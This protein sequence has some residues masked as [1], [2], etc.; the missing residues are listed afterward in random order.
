MMTHSLVSVK[1]LD[2]NITYS[3]SKRKALLKCHFHD[4]SIA[5]I[6]HFI[7][8]CFCLIKHQVRFLFIL[9]SAKVQSYYMPI[10][11]KG[12]QTTREYTS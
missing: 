2:E 5:P 11:S 9:L 12:L 1:Y 3:N 8:I 10:F 4:C 7:S 6:S